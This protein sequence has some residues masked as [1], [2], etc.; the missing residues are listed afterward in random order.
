MPGLQTLFNHREPTHTEPYIHYKP[1]KRKTKKKRERKRLEASK[2]YHV[3]I[4]AGSESKSNS[5]G[6]KVHR[7]KTA[8]KGIYNIYIHGDRLKSADL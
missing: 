4:L 1:L 7:L 8:K 2:G 5:A 3:Y 6:A